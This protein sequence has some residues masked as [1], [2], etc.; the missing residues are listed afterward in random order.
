LIKSPIPTYHLCFKR[1]NFNSKIQI[2][3][4]NNQYNLCHY[5][6]KHYAKQ[7][8]QNLPKWIWKQ[9]SEITQQM[10]LLKHTFGKQH[11][12]KGSKNNNTKCNVSIMCIVVKNE[13]DNKHIMLF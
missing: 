7:R 3:H 9:T 1:K 5:K 6:N 8:N 10:Q 2:I 12:C 13:F 11:V 4:C